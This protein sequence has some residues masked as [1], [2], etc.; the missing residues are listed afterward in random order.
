MDL[1]FSR[2]EVLTGTGAMFLCLGFVCVFSEA[3]FIEHQLAA[4]VLETVHEQDLFWSSVEPHGQEILLTGA[5]RDAESV[6]RAGKLASLVAG[7]STLDNQIIVIG[8]VGA[9]QK[10]MDVLTTRRRVTFKTG[11]ANLH[12]TSM[13]TLNKLARL[14]RLCGVVL[15][16]AGHMDSVGDSNVNL[17]LSQRRAEAVRVQLI[18]GGVRA[19]DV[20]ARGYGEKQPIADNDSEEGRMANRRVEFR[21]LGSAV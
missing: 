10:E 18:R 12:D 17:K 21:V 5:A 4:R 11:R 14:A 7:V 13:P 16:V 8:E 1:R 9:C 19:Q 15:E 20:S 6:K 3:S 2:F